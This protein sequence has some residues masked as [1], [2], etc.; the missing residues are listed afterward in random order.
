MA[1]HEQTTRLSPVGLPPL[2]LHHFFTWTAATAGLLALGSLFDQETD[3]VAHWWTLTW[4][5][6]L[7]WYSLALTCCGFGLHWRRQGLPFPSQPGHAILLVG[8]CGYIL[9]IGLSLLFLAILGRSKLTEQLVDASWYEWI[10]NAYQ[11]FVIASYVWFAWW[12]RPA[13][14]WQV[15][16]LLQA[17]W[18]AD[19]YF[20]D[21]ILEALLIQPISNL[22][23]IGPGLA[24]GMR[25]VLQQMPGLIPGTALVVAILLDRRDRIPRHWSHWAGVAAYLVAIPGLIAQA[26][27]NAGWVPSPFPNS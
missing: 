26:L 10:S 17:M 4:L 16:F 23:W 11:V 20:I 21:R 18:T 6:S 5:P 14:R 13:R 12:S 8:A 2:R 9:W 22:E 25:F 19:F 27:L 24:L 1:T 3:H 7:L 15:F